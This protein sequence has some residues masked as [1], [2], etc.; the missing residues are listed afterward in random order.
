[1]K[2]I[3]KISNIRDI[4]CFFI[5]HGEL[6]CFN[7]SRSNKQG[8][9]FLEKMIKN[10]FFSLNEMYGDNVSFIVLG[11]N[12]RRNLNE[13]IPDRIKKR[14]VSIDHPVI[15][16][17]DVHIKSN[18][19]IKNGKII[20]SMISNVNRHRGR[21]L[22]DIAK[23][24][25]DNIRINI[26]IISRILDKDIISEF[27][28]ANITLTNINGD[29]IARKDYVK[30]ICESDFILFLYPVSDYRFT[31]SGAI[32]DAISNYKPILALRNDYFN[33]IFSLV[34]HFGILA[35]NIDE[36]ADLV[37]ILTPCN[38]ELELFDKLR[39]YFSPENISR[40]LIER[41]I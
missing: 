40:Q 16:S 32:F 1:M 21:A 13:I 15:F 8:G 11:E 27:I 2:T 35:D 10:V 28:D 6:E 14:I 22:L 9:K 41:C 34:G 19:N 5:C 36:I 33:Y 20:V 17:N 26:Q 3:Q 18:T 31:A 29:T 30:K 37:N 12:I 7:Q 38:I 24:I 39:V 4:K 25:S 23:K